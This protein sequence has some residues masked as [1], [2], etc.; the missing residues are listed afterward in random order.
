M[1]YIFKY[2]VCRLVVDHHLK[3]YCPWCRSV[4]FSVCK[5]YYL[6][7]RHCSNCGNDMDISYFKPG[8]FRYDSFSLYSCEEYYVIDSF[9]IF[10]GISIS[11]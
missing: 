3:F 9:S 2:H 5:E 4:L 1:S 11:D 7:M 10:Q 6:V 8:M